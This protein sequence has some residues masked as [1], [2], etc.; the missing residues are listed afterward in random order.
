[1]FIVDETLFYFVADITITAGQGFSEFPL[2]FFPSLS[3]DQIYKSLWR[4]DLAAKRKV[5]VVYERAKDGSVIIEEEKEERCDEKENK[6]FC[7]TGGA[8]MEKKK[9]KCGDNRRRKGAEQVAVCLKIKVP[10]GK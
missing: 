1:M 10:G 6:P 7:R 5:F 8:M 4:P 2:F 9:L 3:S